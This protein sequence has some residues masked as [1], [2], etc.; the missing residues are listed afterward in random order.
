MLLT[1]LLVACR[2]MLL[3]IEATAATEACQVTGKYPSGMNCLNKPNAKIKTS[4][5]LSTASSVT[6]NSCLK[7][8][9]AGYNETLPDA[10]P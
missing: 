9:T 2:M 7:Q 4:I 6:V 10:P 3:M 1:Y 8:L 5:I